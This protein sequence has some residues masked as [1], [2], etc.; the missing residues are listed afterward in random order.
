MNTKRKGYEREAPIH[1][2]EFR[3]FSHTRCVTIFRLPRSIARVGIVSQRRIR[4]GLR[5]QV[6]ATRRERYDAAFPPRS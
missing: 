6:L 5:V 3:I 1:I 2:I 4:Y